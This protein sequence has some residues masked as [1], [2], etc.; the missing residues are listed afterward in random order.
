MLFILL[1]WFYILAVSMIVG[2]STSKVLGITKSH[3]VITI[4]LGFFSVTIIASFWAILY[5]VNWPFHIVLFL[6]CCCLLFLNYSLIKKNLVLTVHQF[7]SLSQYIKILFGVIS[8]L[9]LAQCASPPFLIDNESYYIQTIKWLN[10]YGFV[11]GL[12]NLH[13]FLGQTS[14][15]H[16]LQSAFNFSFLY[17]SFNDLSGL[18]LLLGNYYAITHLNSYSFKSKLNTAD[19]I[20]ALFPI[21]NVFFF[22]FISTPSPDM[23][24]YVLS[25]II[26]HQFLKCY[27]NFDKNTYVSLTTISLFA[28]LIKPS[29]IVFAILP[30]MLYR[31]YF[32]YTR[33]QTKSLFTMTFLV[34]GIIIVKN[35]IIAG[36]PFFPL[37]IA[38]LIDFSWQLP[39]DIASYF[40][41]YGRAYGYH[42][43]PESFG[44]ASWSLRFKTWLFVPGLHGIFNKMMIALLIIIPLVIYKF[45]NKTTYW[46]FYVLGILSMI[47]LFAISPQ[48]RFYFPIMMIFGLMICRLLIV[49]SKA[50]NVV[51][52]LATMIVAIPLFFSINNQQVTNNMYHVANSQFST[53]Y[54][55]EPFGLSKYPSG[56]EVIQE[57]NLKFNSPTQMDFF[58]GTGDIPLPAINK[59]QHKYFKVNFNVMPQQFSENLKHGFISKRVKKN[60]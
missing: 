27:E 28:I 20:I 45:Y 7:N 2:T 33:S 29:V 32:I 50:L 56:Y 59:E 42:M 10:E 36:N 4:I 41:N 51:M 57:S 18:I 58:W 21:L 40:S 6:I 3:P 24:I 38:N 44:A 26:T 22:Q 30:I 17:D 60:N 37:T 31:R 25:L 12:V 47:L 16:I 11:K 1:S 8:L 55:V 49:N 46:L 5:S 52:F 13:L 43:S 19:S 54:L 34:A 39:S 23:A 35:S 53:D 9:I 14:G 48:Y 15:W